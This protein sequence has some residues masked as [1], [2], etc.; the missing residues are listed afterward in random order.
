MHSGGVIETSSQE[1]KD[2]TCDGA[3]LLGLNPMLRE[4]TITSCHAAWRF[5]I[6]YSNTRA[7]VTLN[8][9]CSWRRTD[10]MADVYDYR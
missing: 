10:P 8:F 2:N 9:G 5:R 3:D 4:T 1:R 6:D 7:V